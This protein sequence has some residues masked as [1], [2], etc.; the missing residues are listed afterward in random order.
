MFQNHVCRTVER[1]EYRTTTICPNKLHDFTVVSPLYEIRSDCKS[2]KN[3]VP[4]PRIK[5]GEKDIQVDA[6]MNLAAIKQHI[7]E[8]GNKM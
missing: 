2:E 5:R 4:G 7:S 8:N 3:K 6:D 1:P